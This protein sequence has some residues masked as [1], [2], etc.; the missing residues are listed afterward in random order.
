MIAGVTNYAACK[1]GWW[2]ARRWPG[3][4][5]GDIGRGCAAALLALAGTRST[6]EAWKGD[7]RRRLV[8]PV[9]LGHRVRVI[10]QLGRGDVAD[11]CKRTEHALGD[12]RRRDAEAVGSIVNSHPDFAFTHMFHVCMENLGVL[13]T[14]QDF[15]RFSESDTIG[16]KRLWIPAWATLT[17][18]SYARSA[19][20]WN[21][22]AKGVELQVHP[23]ADDLFRV[24]FSSG[25]TAVSLR[26]GNPKF[27]MGSTRGRKVPASWVLADLWPPVEFADIELRPAFKFGSVHLPLGEELDAAA[28]TLLRCFPFASPYPGL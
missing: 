27:R 11:V 1:G 17:I 4:G 8:A 13:L 25:R 22:G 24:D 3:R 20:S 10:Y 5:A 26:V 19:R 2:P 23:V 9:V 28:A 21:C 16:R 15:R 7:E 18:A 14:Y 6:Y 12:V